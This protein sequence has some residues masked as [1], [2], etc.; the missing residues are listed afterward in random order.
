MNEVAIIQSLDTTLIDD[1]EA[2]SRY[3]KADIYDQEEFIRS[4]NLI[5]LYK[6]YL[7][8]SGALNAPQR[9]RIL[10]GIVDNLS[11]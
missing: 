5:E 3:W 1:A 10:Q 2:L 8:T 7:N 11:Y 4:V 6:A 9:A